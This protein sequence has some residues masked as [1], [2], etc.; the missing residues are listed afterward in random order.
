MKRA[1]KIINLLM[2]IYVLFSMGTA[3]ANWILTNSNGGDGYVV[4]ASLYPVVKF[5][6]YGADNAIEDADFS[7]LTIYSTIINYSDSFNISWIYHTYDIDG[8]YWDPAGYVMNGNFNQLSSDDI[9]FNGSQTGS[10][11]ILLNAGDFFGFYVYSLDSLAGRGEIT[12]EIESASV[13]EPSLVM[14]LISGLL[15]LVTFPRMLRRR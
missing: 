13:P 14:L 15:G 7:N 1:L 11:T 9:L 6:L 8:S 10:F 2:F 12:V 5:D 3:H 4:D